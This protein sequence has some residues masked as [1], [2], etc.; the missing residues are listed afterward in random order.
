VDPVYRLDEVG[1]PPRAWDVAVVAHRLLDYAGDPLDPGLSNDEVE[2][3]EARFDFRFAP[4]HRAFLSIGMPRGPQW[5]NWRRGSLRVLRSRMQAPV[6]GVVADV[7]EHDFWP[8]GWERRPA[9]DAER[10]EVARDRLATV[11][12]LVPLFADCYLPADDPRPRAPVLAVDRTIVSVVG[13][14][15][16]HY[17]GRVFAVHDPA[18]AGRPLH[19][20]FWSDLAA[21]H[22]PSRRGPGIMDPG[23]SAGTR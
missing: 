12:T 15:L 3:V 20:P 21:L 2:R 9:A 23:R 17:V 7:L 1:S 4:V 18:P 14:D 5:P 22:D 10:E 16:A 8:A 19:V 6:D 13:H 11:P